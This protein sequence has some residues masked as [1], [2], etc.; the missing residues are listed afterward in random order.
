MT[1]RTMDE[2][3]RWLALLVALVWAP[4]GNS[5]S[6]IDFEPY[7][8]ETRD[9]RQVDAE[10]GRIRV[11]LNR[12]AEEPG[13]L[14]LAFVRLPALAD[15]PG[16]PVVYLAGGPGGSGVQAGRGARFEL[17]QGLRRQYDVILLDQRGTGMS[18]GPEPEECPVERRYPP[19][20]PLELEHYLEMVE[21]VAA[22]CRRFWES[23][24]VDLDAYDTVE[25]AEDIEALRR[26]LSTPR[27]N[28]LGISY[29][30]HL[31]LAYMKRFP[32]KVHRAVLAGVE[33]P[34]HTVKLPV[35]FERQLQKLEALLGDDG[36]LRS[37]V[38]RVLADLEQRPVAI[39][40]ID[41]EGPDRATT[42]V[43]GRREVA[44]LTLD[45][46]RDPETMIRLP[47]IYERLEAGDFTDL[48]GPLSG[49]RRVGGLEAMPEAMDAA[50]G[51]SEA[52]LTRLIDQEETTLL[53]SG[54]LRA[55]VAVAQGLGV[56]DLGV[57]FRTP[58]ESDTPTLFISG[59]LDGR[60][61]HHNAVEVMRGFS[62]GQHHLVVNGG[63]GNDLLV[64]T[65]ELE[66]A[67][68]AFLEDEAVPSETR[69]PPPDP[70]RVPGRIALSP[71]DAARYV[72][73]Y[74]RRPRELW[75][76]LHH[77]TVQ[78]LDEEGDE[79]FANA[80]LQIRWGGNGFPFHP[81]S[82]AEFFID[83][84]WFAGVEFE[85]EMDESGQ[86]THLIFEDSAGETVRMEKV[87]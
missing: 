39:R 24:G 32:D 66:S 56:P 71:E 60:T 47:R 12:D 13:E 77:N 49:L 68:V 50:S 73:E 22:E 64:A 35:Q 23:H 78:S 19:D 84:P 10:L 25:S 3:L 54:L 82:E 80:V 36:A 44:E 62:R 74:E 52:R 7:T 76:I 27:L 79:R 70:K 29:G 26:A 46:L 5:E 8:Y 55:N 6:R 30:S 53:G 67:I 63:H 69:L 11:P 9:A 15:D 83:F 81:V 57:D 72:G 33:G 75:R 38:Q 21:A 87:H 16:P 34:D 42:L 1:E 58:L 85:F 40:V 31:G 51:I 45:L 65:P 2:Y 59:S 37:R 4:A 43:V 86:V 14:T 28:L 20:R 61:P 17:F 41:V 48:A 18:E